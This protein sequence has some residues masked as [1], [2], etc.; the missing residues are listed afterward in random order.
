MLYWITAL[1]LFVMC[2]IFNKVS[3]KLGL[4]CISCHLSTDVWL[5]SRDKLA[6]VE[7][8][9][10]LWMDWW[11]VLR[12]SPGAMAIMNVNAIDIW[13][14]LSFQL[15]SL[16][17]GRWI[18]VYVTVFSANVSVWSVKLVC[19]WLLQCIYLWC[20]CRPLIISNVYR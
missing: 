20:S 9:L 8:Y 18:N 7:Y 4:F 3:R 17:L 10:Y 16:D 15:T 5:Y 1:S 2:H 14:K 19:V 12:G 11:H 6:K 13:F